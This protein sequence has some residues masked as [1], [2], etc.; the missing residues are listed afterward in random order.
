MNLITDN[1]AFLRLILDNACPMT[2]DEQTGICLFAIETHCV[3]WYVEAVKDEDG[4]QVLTMR[5]EPC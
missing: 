4:W 1:A 5:S 3:L 2:K